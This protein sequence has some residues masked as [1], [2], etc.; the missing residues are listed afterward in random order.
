MK[1]DGKW[2]NVPSHYHCVFFDSDRQPVTRAWVKSRFIVKFSKKPPSGAC[3]NYTTRLNNAV[4][5][6]D[7]AAELGLVERRKKFCFL[8]R[9]KGV[10]GSP[11]TEEE[12]EDEVEVARDELGRLSKEV[13]RSGEILTQLDVS[14]NPQPSTS[15]PP[16]CLK[17]NT[18]KKKRKQSARWIFSFI[19]VIP[20]D[21]S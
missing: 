16:D 17:T 8:A 20:L 3:K 18:K 4:Q 12:P 6:L 2:E 19:N 10:W 5:N 1:G 11:W 13:P 15:A 9:F 14:L 7:K 21:H